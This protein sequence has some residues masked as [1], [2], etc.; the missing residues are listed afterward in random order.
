[1]WCGV[2]RKCAAT[3]S[4]KLWER[5]GPDGGKRANRLDNNQKTE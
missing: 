2:S 1:L 3:G 4:T 5:L